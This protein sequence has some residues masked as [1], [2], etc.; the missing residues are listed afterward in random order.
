MAYVAILFGLGFIMYGA[1][2]LAGLR[3]GRI[4]HESDKGPDNDKRVSDS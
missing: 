3:S 2:F 4:L 1:G